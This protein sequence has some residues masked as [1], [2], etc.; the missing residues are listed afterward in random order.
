MNAGVAE[1]EGVGII[2]EI[3]LFEDSPF[4]HDIEAGTL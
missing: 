1:Q 3:D 4:D 2:C